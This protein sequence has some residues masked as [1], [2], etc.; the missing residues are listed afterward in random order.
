MRRAPLHSRLLSSPSVCSVIVHR[1]AQ[2]ILGEKN[3]WSAATRIGG[4]HGSGGVTPKFYGAVREQ[5]PRHDHAA[6][7]AVAAAAA[8]VPSSSAAGGGGLS[9]P[10]AAGQA[11]LIGQKLAF[12][13]SLPSPKRPA[14][15]G[16]VG[17]KQHGEQQPEVRRRSIAQSSGWVTPPPSAGTAA[18]AVSNGDVTGGPQA[19]GEN[20]A[21]G[22]AAASASSGHRVAD[23]NGGQKH[24]KT[25]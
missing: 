9:S 5:P 16:G 10:S 13:G 3:D 18:A 21:G 1:L 25:A 2:S 22:L 20:G 11:G 7:A 24:K 12:Y 23:S 14:G 8:V 6:G 19:V 15:D 4:P 17:G